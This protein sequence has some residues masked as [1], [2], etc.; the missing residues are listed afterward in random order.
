MRQLHGVIIIPY[1][2]NMIKEVGILLVKLLPMIDL[3]IHQ[4]GSPEVLMRVKFQHV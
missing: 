2:I 4:E 3:Y 1:P